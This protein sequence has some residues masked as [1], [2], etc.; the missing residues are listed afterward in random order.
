MQRPPNS[1]VVDSSQQTNFSKSFSEHSN[2]AK[3]ET[4]LN[5]S[6]KITVII[7]TLN[8]EK[9]IS[10]IVKEL[11]QL[12]FT[13]ILMIDGNST[14]GTVEIAQ[15]LG[16]NVLHQNGKGK[17]EALRQAF[18]YTQLSDWVVMLDADGS[19]DPKEIFRF[20]EHLNNGID[21]VKGS[22]FMP[23]GF[24]EDMT[25]FRR[26]GNAVF[27]HLVNL[28]WGAKYTDLCYGFAAFKKEAL[29]TLQPYL[30]SK[31]FEIETELF[32]KAK[33]LHLNVIEVPSIELRRKYGKSN[34]NS[35]KDGFLIFKTIMHEALFD[36]VEY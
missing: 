20:L 6:N 19:M 12:G 25:L 26:M 34:L 35:F 17:G 31:N 22:R 32:I 18:D 8:E 24:S 3:I 9:N 7:P 29:L 4:S 33:K 10:S 5:Q 16:V 30:E 28:I 14:D 11:H 15:E 2:Y 27:V 1:S 23:F 36:T 21:V 13:N